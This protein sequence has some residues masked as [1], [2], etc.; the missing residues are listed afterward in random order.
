MPGTGDLTDGPFSGR[1]Q[2]VARTGGGLYVAY[3]AGYPSH[4]RVLL[5]HI[6]SARSSV[7]GSA[8]GDV[9][10]V[11]IAATPTGRLWT[12]WSARSSSGSPIV[13]SRRSDAHATHW[14]ATVALRPPSGAST[15]WNLVG[16]GQAAL[17]DLVGSFSVGTNNVI[18]S[19]HTQVLPGLSL[20]GSPGRLRAG[21]GRAQKV[22]FYVSDAGAPVRGVKVRTGGAHGT[23][24]GKGKVTLILG[25][26][27]RPGHLTVTGSAAGYTAASLS[28]PVR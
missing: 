27:R 28:I 18:S 11:G 8:K 20:S 6:G 22:T 1:T 5:W 19:W 9:A 24:N 13:Y 14:G 15:S 3:T 21:T 7:L 25:P 10:S 2:I 23:T 16:N 17:L 4:S 12:F 26:Y